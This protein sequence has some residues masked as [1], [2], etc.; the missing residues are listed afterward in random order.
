MYLAA[1][2]NYSLFY[3]CR[4][5]KQ[6]FLSVFSRFSTMLFHLLNIFSSGL[7]SIYILLLN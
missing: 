2:A 3:Y 1:P 4:Y 6:C 7:I 5:P